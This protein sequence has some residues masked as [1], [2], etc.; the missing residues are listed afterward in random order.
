M[1]C[2][3][4]LTKDIRGDPTGLFITSTKPYRKAS[5]SRWIKGMHRQ[6]GNILGIYRPEACN[7]IKKETLAQVFSCEFCEISKNTFFYRTPLVAASGSV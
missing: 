4:D 5:M 3:I 6:A 7:L 1:K 2:Y